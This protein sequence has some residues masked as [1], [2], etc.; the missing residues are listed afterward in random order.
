[1]NRDKLQW[2]VIGVRGGWLRGIDDVLLILPK[3]DLSPGHAGVPK[4]GLVYSWEKGE[5]GQRVSSSTGFE[6]GWEKLGDP[7]PKRAVGVHRSLFLEE[8]KGAVGEYYAARIEESMTREEYPPQPY[9][10]APLLTV[11]VY[12]TVGYNQCCYCGHENKGVYP[13]PSCQ[14][15]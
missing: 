2:I 11:V 12:K 6:P 5:F 14:S 4:W 7:L 10:K 9:S 3:E 13:C 15:S 8:K 1:M